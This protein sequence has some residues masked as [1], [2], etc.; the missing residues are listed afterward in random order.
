MDLYGKLIDQCLGTSS[1]QYSYLYVPAI[2]QH[3]SCSAGLKAAVFF[4]N[5]LAFILGA[6]RL[7]VVPSDH[8]WKCFRESAGGISLLDADQGVCHDLSLTDDVVFRSLL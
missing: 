1:Y 6:F 7:G 5:L 8:D 2:S 3:L 4:V